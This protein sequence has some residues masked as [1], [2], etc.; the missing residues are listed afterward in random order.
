MLT[1]IALIY[2]NQG[3]AVIPVKGPYYAEGSTEEER[4]KD[5]K[6]PLVK[7]TDYQVKAPSE[8]LVRK[9][10]TRWNQANIAVITGRVSGIVVVDFDSEEAVSYAKKQGLLNAPLVQTGRGLHAYFKYPEGRMV[11]N[12]VNSAMKIDIRGD[13]G[14]VVIPPSTHF[15]GTEYTW[16]AGHHLGEKELAP[17]PEVFI[18]GASQGPGDK[19]PLKGLYRGVEAGGRNHAL[20]RLVGSWVCDGLEPE[21]CLENAI[22]WNQR[23]TPPL[24]INEI[25]SVVR[26]IYKKHARTT[27][28]GGK[29]EKALYER[30]LLKQPLFAC[31]KRVHKP[32]VIELSK[33][34]DGVDS[35]LAISCGEPYGLGGPFDD[36]VFVTLSKLL[37]ELPKPIANPVRIESLNKIASYY[38]SC[39]EDKDIAKIKDSLMRL[40][41]TSINSRYTFYDKDKKRIVDDTFRIINQIKFIGHSINIWLGELYLSNLNNGGPLPFDYSVYVSLATYPARTIYKILCPI[42]I[43]NNGSPITVKYSTICERCQVDKADTLFPAK[44]K[45]QHS[46]EELQ[47]RGIIAAVK[48]VTLKN[49][50]Y[51]VYTPKKVVLP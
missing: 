30:N 33:S 12:A 4:S 43:T 7:W 16:V 34:R 27:S 39:P 28:S 36:L 46:H 6:A 9:W 37:S 1:D 24:A 19:T 21:E 22:I 38:L 47:K 20:A 3:K 26:S 14:Y 15:S 29:K 13:G 18:H 8:E 11:G 2:L 41:H 31:G 48:W 32:G 10:F 42:F 44:K 45:L 17:L 25:E 49:T 50:T 40:A 35:Q 23:N 5:S 51:I